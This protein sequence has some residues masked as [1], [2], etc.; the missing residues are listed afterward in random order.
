MELRLAGSRHGYGPRRT[1]PAR[2]A[3]VNLAA[4]RTG[5]AS[6]RFVRETDGHRPDKDPDKVTGRFNGLAIRF[7]R[8]GRNHQ[9]GTYAASALAPLPYPAPQP[10]TLSGCPLT[11]MIRTRQG[12]GGIPGRLADDRGRYVP[13][14]V[15]N[16]SA[17]AIGLDGRSASGTRTEM[18]MTRSLILATVLSAALSAAA[19]GQ[20]ICDDIRQL[21]MGPVWEEASAAFD[22]GKA[23]ADEDYRE[24]FQTAGVIYDQ[25]LARAEAAYD[26]ALHWIF[27]N[28]DPLDHSAIAY[29]IADAVAKRAHDRNAAHREWAS[30]VSNMMLRWSASMEEA[31][32]DRSVFLGENVL[33]VEKQLSDVCAGLQD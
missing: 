18:A 22:A 20:T 2:V 13:A 1:L 12:L 23:K 11:G 33:L 29:P 30:S 25:A 7:H 15:R 19:W 27:K 17:P 8:H 24:E 10:S 14:C 6:I 32:T 28:A 21:S 16:R 3:D 26:G 9:S 4:S 31:E 5:V